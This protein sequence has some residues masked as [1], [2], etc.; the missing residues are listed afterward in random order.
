MG[1]LL[2]TIVF[3]IIYLIIS[4]FLALNI[5]QISNYHFEYS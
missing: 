5:S 3:A 4:Y 1:K 2:K